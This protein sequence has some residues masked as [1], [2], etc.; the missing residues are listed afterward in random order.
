[1]IELYEIGIGL[2][3]LSVLL[4]VFTLVLYYTNRDVHDW[5][6]WV[7]I[8]LIILIFLGLFLILLY[9]NYNDF[10]YNKMIIAPEVTPEILI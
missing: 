8:A 9:H 3:I 7:F 6:F 5:M 10:Y 4:M 1:M 2:I